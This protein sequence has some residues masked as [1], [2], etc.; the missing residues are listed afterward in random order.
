MQAIDLRD[1]NRQRLQKGPFYGKQLFG[2]RPDVL[3]ATAVDL[4]AP[5]PYRRHFCK[6]N[7][8]L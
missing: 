4:V 8:Q 6:L 1:P 5:V 7:E 3:V 2:N